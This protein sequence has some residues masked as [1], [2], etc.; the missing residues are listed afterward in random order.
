MSAATIQA[1]EHAARTRLESLRSELTERL[2]ELYLESAAWSARPIRIGFL[3]VRG[4]C[5]SS[6]LAAWYMFGR[7][8]LGCSGNAHGRNRVDLRPDEASMAKLKEIA[9]DIRQNGT[10]TATAEARPEVIRFTLQVG[11]ERV[12]LEMLDC[13]RPVKQLL[14]RRG[15]G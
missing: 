4:A 10:A 12:H 1:Q 5:K 9:A 8:G 2:D 14:E 6:L 13:P 3:G 7:E 15:S 11:Q